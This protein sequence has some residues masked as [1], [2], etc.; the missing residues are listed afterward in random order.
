MKSVYG[1]KPFSIRDNIRMN[2]TS[3]VVEEDSKNS[4]QRA[5]AFESY[6]KCRPKKKGS[7]I[8]FGFVALRAVPRIVANKNFSRD[9]TIPFASAFKTKVPFKTKLSTSDECFLDIRYQFMKLNR[10]QSMRRRI[11]Q[12]NKKTFSSCKETD[13]FSEQRRKRKRLNST[14]YLR[15][16]LSKYSVTND[17]TNSESGS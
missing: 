11:N 15:H 14:P 10:Y 9:E 16:I 3:D 2:S 7:S 17:S 5:H 4:E 1:L 12:N 8:K 13:R 6:L